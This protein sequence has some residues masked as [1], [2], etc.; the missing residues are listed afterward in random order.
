MTTMKNC[1]YDRLWLL[2]NSFFVFLPALLRINVERGKKLLKLSPRAEKQRKRKRHTIS[3]K[4]S[5]E[6]ETSLG[7][8]N[9]NDVILDWVWLNMCERQRRDSTNLLP[10]RAQIIRSSIQI[11][12]RHHVWHKFHDFWRFAEWN[13]LL[14]FFR[15]SFF[16]SLMLRIEFRSLR[17]FQQVFNNRES[18]I[19]RFSWRYQIKKMRD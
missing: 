4:M 15:A 3:L 5:K 19:R 9:W 16:P 1:Y 13:N 10:K 14:V 11:I 8:I 12:V 6:N 7:K 18:K 17:D 2:W